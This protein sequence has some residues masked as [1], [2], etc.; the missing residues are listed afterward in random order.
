VITGAHPLGDLMSPSYLIRLLGW[1]GFLNLVRSPR[2]KVPE[3][4]APAVV[5]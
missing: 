5:S 4:A 3:V 2:P 1:R